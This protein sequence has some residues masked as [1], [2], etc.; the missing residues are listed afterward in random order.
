MPSSDITTARKPWRR[1]SLPICGPTFSTPSTAKEPRWAWD[2]SAAAT[3]GLTPGRR[4]RRLKSL[5]MPFLARSA[6]IAEA[7]GS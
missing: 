1:S 6:T 5:N 4:E 7:T 3:A 2:C